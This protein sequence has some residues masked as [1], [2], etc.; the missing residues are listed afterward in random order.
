[1]SCI[2]QGISFVAACGSCDGAFDQNVVGLRGFRFVSGMQYLI[3]ENQRAHGLF[4]VRQRYRGFDERGAN[5]V[6]AEKKE[7]ES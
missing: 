4:K 3:D 6:K 7:S 2:A 1:M 5:S